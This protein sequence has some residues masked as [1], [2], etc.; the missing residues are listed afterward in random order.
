MFVKSLS[1]HIPSPISNKAHGGISL[2]V[3]CFPM[4]WT[5]VLSLVGEL[6]SHMPWDN[7]AHE[8]QLE[9]PIHG[10]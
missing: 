7:L 8:L 10:N 2:V 5:W 6:S 3:Q 9:K 4:L 1:D